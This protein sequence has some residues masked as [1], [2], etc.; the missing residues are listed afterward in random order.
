MA[1]PSKSPRKIDGLFFASPCPRPEKFPVPKG[2]KGA[3]ARGLAYEKKVIRA[4]QRKFPTLKYHQWFHFSDVNGIGYCE[5]EAF[6]EFE[7]FIFLVECKLTGG[8]L[9]HLQM[10]NLYEPVLRHH[11]KKPVRRLLIVKYLTPNTPRPLF[12]SPEA[13]LKSGQLMGTWHLLDP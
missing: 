6:V 10:A 9:G 3:K 12:G 5:P 13:F 11:F 7:D 8:P 2:R 4:L 1:P